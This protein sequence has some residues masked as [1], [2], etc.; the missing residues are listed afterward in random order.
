VLAVSASLWLLGLAQ[1]HAGP[2]GRLAHAL[3]RSAYC[4]FLVQGLLL[5]GLA[6]TLR[7][8]AVPAE[9]KVPC[10]RLRRYRR[11]ASAGM[12]ARPRTRLGRIL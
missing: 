9:V 7:P 1:R 4:A 12:A 5:I 6:L 10:L 3:A 8:L 11:L 2:C